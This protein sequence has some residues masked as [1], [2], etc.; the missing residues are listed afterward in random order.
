[1]GAEKTV[2]TSSSAQNGANPAGA[3]NLRA[4]A[5]RI[6]PLL[7]E[8]GSRLVPHGQDRYGLFGRRSA[9]RRSKVTLPRAM[10]EAF[11]R[12]DWLAPCPE[13]GAPALTL[14]AEGA[15]FL[16][17]AALPED[18]FRAQHR[19]PGLRYVAANGTEPAGRFAVNLA[20]TPL[21]WLARHRMPDGMPMITAAQFDAGERLRE[22]FTAAQLMRRTTM[23]WQQWNIDTSGGGDKQTLSDFALEARVRL[24][25]ALEAA[26][27]GMAEL[28]IDVCC[29]LEGL[30]QTERMRSWP[31]GCG[32]VVLALGLERLARHYGFSRSE[33]RGTRRRTA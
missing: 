13:R 17:R 11:L 18:P 15:A 26:G 28:L 4:E 10:I 21:G 8:P 1:M 14:S 31:R 27:P 16:R 6:L 12:E 30:E 33:A 19:V 9:G 29:Y 24:S 22:D 32:R 3:P 5:Y 7:E 23:D 25:A 20:E 2:A